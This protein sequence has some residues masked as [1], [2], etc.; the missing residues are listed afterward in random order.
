[1]PKILHLK[2]GPRLLP[3]LGVAAAV[4]F[5]DQVTKWLVMEK[6]LAAG[7]EGQDAIALFP[8][9]N[10]VMVWNRGVSFGLFDTGAPAGALFF[11][12]LSLIICT[13]LSCWLAVTPKK[14]A[15][16]AL[17]LVIG[18]AMGNVIDRL[19]FGAVADFIDVYVQ[20]W[21]W[22]A[23]NLADSA[24]VIGA[25]LLMLDALKEEKTKS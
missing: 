16:I 15:G 9:L 20:N 14:M 21:H 7:A 11:A 8:G 17:G 4:T 19:R 18:G 10:I 13:A 22:P 2:T 1:M 23:F 6:L 12:A 24:I 5:S 3:G 25:G